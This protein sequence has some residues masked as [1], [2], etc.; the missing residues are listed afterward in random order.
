M[1][2]KIVVKNLHKVFGS[3][4]DLAMNMLKDGHG[5]IIFFAR[6]VW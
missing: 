5:K 2:E 1:A 3:D 6:Q 4:P